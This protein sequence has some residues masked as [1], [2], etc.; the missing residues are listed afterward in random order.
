MILYCDHK[1]TSQSK[2][3]IVFA[4]F[5]DSSSHDKPDRH[6]DSASRR[7]K[8]FVWPAAAAN[9]SSVAKDATV[10][11]RHRNSSRR[12]GSDGGGDRH[13]VTTAADR[14]FCSVLLEIERFSIHLTDPDIQLVLNWVKLSSHE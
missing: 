1:S 11:L 9:S 10:K 6:R 7:R 13:P 2:H 4:E 8:P 3:N 12:L 5:M 14:N